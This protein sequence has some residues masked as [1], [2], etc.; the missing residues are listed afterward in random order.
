MLD[1][2]ALAIKDLLAVLVVQE[3]MELMVVAETTELQVKMVHPQ[4]ST[5]IRNLSSLPNVL[6]KPTLGRKGTLVPKVQLDSRVRMEA[7]DSLEAMG[8]QVH[9]VLPDHQDQAA[10]QDPKVLSEMLEIP[11]GKP[12]HLDLQVFLEPLDALDPQAPT[13]M[14]EKMEDPEL[15]AHPAQMDRLEKLEEMEAPDLRD[16]L[17]TLAHQDLA[18]T[19]HR[20]DWRPAIK[21]EMKSILEH[22]DAFSFFF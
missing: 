12:V 4:H 19:A 7:L 10:D 3:L 14:L 21:N 9:K 18:A 8:N 17:E 15:K 16:H 1:P 6:A 13:E 20:P 5:T 11:P 2:A 22:F